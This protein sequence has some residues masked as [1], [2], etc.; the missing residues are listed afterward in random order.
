MKLTEEEVHILTLQKG[1][2]YYIF[3]FTPET[4]LRIIQTLG[5]WASNPELAFNWYDAARLSRELRGQ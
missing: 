2:E 3:M 1:R 5:E 4:R